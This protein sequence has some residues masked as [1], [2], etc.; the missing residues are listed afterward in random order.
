MRLIPDKEMN[1]YKTY[2]YHMFKNV[3]D[4]WAFVICPK[5][6]DFDAYCPLCAVTSKLYQGSGA[7]KPKAYQMKRKRKHCVNSYIK[8]DPRDENNENKSVG[9]VLVYEFPDAVEKKIKAEM[10]D[11]EYGAGVNI[12]EPGKEG[13]DFILKVGA[14]KP[15]PDG[16][17]KG[18]SFPN[19]DLSTFANKAMALGTDD[20]INV[21]MESTHNLD[22]Y[23]KNMSKT[24][25]ELVNIIKDE[26]LFSLIE[27]DY[28]RIHKIV[29][30]TKESHN[31][32]DDMDEIPDEKK[33]IT[34]PSKDTEDE[35]SDEDL[36]SEL[37]NL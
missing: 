21:I 9:K 25:E 10:N 4:K 18:K 13:V 11:E 24:D 15:L 2:H 32:L 37:D 7:D 27:E 36:L 14:T 16:P 17:N 12:F 19:Y 28:N 5:T 20:Q 8:K 6:F 33:K 23:L 29:P 35:I 31:P 30:E 3:N 1:F 26:M 22:E 34:S